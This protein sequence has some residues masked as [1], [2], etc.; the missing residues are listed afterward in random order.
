MLQAMMSSIGVAL[1]SCATFL[2]EPRWLL[3]S[4]VF[5]SVPPP[6]EATE[7]LPVRRRT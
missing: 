5:E 1:L 2:A 6:G 3:L 7:S 4:V